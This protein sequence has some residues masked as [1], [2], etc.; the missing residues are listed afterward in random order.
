M[1]A[2]HRVQGMVAGGN[3]GELRWGV[4]LLALSLLAA[5][6]TGCQEPGTT[7]PKPALQPPT[8]TA[9]PVAKPATAEPKPAGPPRSEMPAPV[10]KPAVEEPKAA[11]PE[12]QVKVVKVAERRIAGKQPKIVVE[13]DTCDL[14]DIGVNTKH[15]GQFKF[16]NKGDAP[17]KVTQVRTCCGV[18]VKGVEAGQEFAPGQGGTL[19]FDYLA[20]DIPNPKLIKKLYLDTNDPNQS[21]A[22]LSIQATIVRRVICKPEIIRLFLKKPNAG[23]TEIALTSLNGKPFSIAGFKATGNTM[24]AAFDPKAQ[25]TEYVITPQVDVAKLGQNMRGQIS[26][27]LTHP[28][29]NNVRVMYDTLAEFEI[30]TPTIMMFGL[31]VGVP[32]QRE[33]WILNNY[34]EK[35]ELESVSS[36]KGT[37]KLVDQAMAGNR[38]HLRVEMT[39]PERAADSTVASDTLQIKIKDRKDPLTVPFRGFYQ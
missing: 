35:F 21:I 30:S 22:T 5:W 29:C 10:A 20:P 18:V 16:T 14:G 37:I 34:E 19:E 31:K 9:A 1:D 33:F 17:L 3:G 24:T 7:A 28:D 32:V 6:G 25:E 8:E 38:C 4:W 36:L 12:P 39:P 11:P 27:D 23:C 15:K 26:I 13:N 2:N